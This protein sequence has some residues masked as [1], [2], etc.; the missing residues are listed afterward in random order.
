[1]ARTKKQ[2]VQAQ[3]KRNLRKIF[4]HDII[5]NWFNEDED[6]ITSQEKEQAVR[7]LQKYPAFAAR[8]DLCRQI[9]STLSSIYRTTDMLPLSALLLYGQNHVTVEDI[10][11]VYNLYPEA[12][13]ENYSFPWDTPLHLACRHANAEVIEFLAH[14]YPAAVYDGNS[15]ERFNAPIK[16]LMIYRDSEFWGSSDFQKAVDVLLDLAPGSLLG[17]VH[18]KYSPSVLADEVDRDQGEFDENCFLHQI[19]QKGLV[20]CAKKIV[21]GNR[22]PETFEHFSVCLKESCTTSVEALAFIVPKLKTFRFEVSEVDKNALSLLEEDL[23]K[24]QSLER[25]HVTWSCESDIVD[26]FLYGVLRKHNNLQELILNDLWLGFN[27]ADCAKILEKENDVTCVTICTDSEDIE[28]IHTD[29]DLNAHL[30]KNKDEL[31][32]IHFFSFWNKHGRRVAS[33]GKMSPA[34]LVSCLMALQNDIATQL[35][36]EIKG[37]I[38]YELLR[39]TPSV[40]IEGSIIR[41]SSAKTILTTIS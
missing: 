20:E 34:V 18:R 27:L 22:L 16:Q 26:N 24:C 32:K 5:R 17:H 6:L 29:F 23:V 28:C 39:G 12:C 40:W 11:L 3:A 30:N 36:N 38:S 2:M 1:M 35:T 33:N 19:I 10:R 4:R 8:R 31:D 37:S 13:A 9:R 41:E 25:L 14:A 7:I 15:R 21:M